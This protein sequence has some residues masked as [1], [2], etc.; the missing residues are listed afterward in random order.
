MRGDFGLLG[1]DG[2]QGERGSAGPPGRKGDSGDEGMCEN[3]YSDSERSM[4]DYVG[5]LNS[6]TLVSLKV[7]SYTHL[8]VPKVVSVLLGLKGLKESEA[9]RGSLGERKDRKGTWGPRYTHFLHV[10]KLHCPNFMIK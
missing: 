3:F 10:C 1:P 2:P 7:N 9:P 4:D 5:F 8:Q 6:L